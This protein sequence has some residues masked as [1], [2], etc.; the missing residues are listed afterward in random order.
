MVVEIIA[1]SPSLQGGDKGVVGYQCKYPWFL[2]SSWFLLWNIST[3]LNILV[4]SVT[5]F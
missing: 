5:F 3:D 2:T 1:F 4:L